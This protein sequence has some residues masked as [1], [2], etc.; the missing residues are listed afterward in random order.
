MRV[1]A[2]MHVLPGVRR[3]EQDPHVLEIDTAIARFFPL[4]IFHLLGFRKR[5]WVKNKLVVSRRRFD[6][7]GPFNRQNVT[8]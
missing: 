6:T 4:Q 2:V 8:G 3:S 1:G 7:A 5:R